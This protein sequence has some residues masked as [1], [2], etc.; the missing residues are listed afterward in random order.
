MIL[1]RYLPHPPFTTLRVICLAPMLS[2]LLHFYLILLSSPEESRPHFHLYVYPLQHWLP[3]FL[4]VTAA[5]DLTYKWQA[6]I[7]RP[8]CHLLCHFVSDSKGNKE[9]DGTDIIQ[10]DEQILLTWMGFLWSSIF[11]KGS[12]PSEI[13]IFL[14]KPFSPHLASVCW[15]SG[16][17]IQQGIKIQDQSREVFSPAARQS[18]LWF[19]LLSSSKAQRQHKSWE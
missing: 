6:E 18:S 19:S 3:L 1:I 5:G 13:L 2:V 7:S 9:K 15:V 14:R 16:C 8:Q 17:E 12:K 11:F 4:I 10:G